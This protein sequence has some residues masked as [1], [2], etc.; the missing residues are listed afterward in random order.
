MTKAIIETSKA[1]IVENYISDNLLQDWI[2]YADV[3]ESTQITYT[4]VARHFL[5]FLSDKG[6]VRPARET[7][8]EYKDFLIKSLKETSARLYFS[9]CKIFLG[10]LTT[11]NLCNAD[12][13]ANVKT[14]KI[15]TDEHRRDYVSADDCRRLLATCDE[16]TEKNLRDKIALSLMMTCGLRT[17]ELHRLN[18]ENFKR[19]QGAFI[20]EIHGKGRNGANEK[21][22]LPVQIAA[23]ISSYINLRK[24]RGGDV[25]KKSPLLVSVSNRCRDSRIEMQSFSRLAKSKLRKIGLDSDD[26][27][28]HSLRHSFAQLSL[29]L[30]KGNTRL[31]SHAL[32][33]RSAKVTEV[34]LHDKEALNNPCS[35]MVA[36]ILF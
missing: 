18:V 27:T 13:I 16:L 21:M 12:V 31:V 6:I 35:R 26:V 15:D 28:A 9:V 4:K 34:Y 7:V 2:E 32:R 19:K 24:K 29:E 22:R 17:V 20:L 36:D 33:H 10:W 25:S 8:I 30:T 3:R 5:R 23:M 1:V 14:I 11:K